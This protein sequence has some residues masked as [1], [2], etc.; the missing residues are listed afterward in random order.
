MNFVF[1]II[2]SPN[3]LCTPSMMDIFFLFPLDPIF[4]AT[5]SS[6]GR[7]TQALFHAPSWELPDAL[8][9]FFSLHSTGN[10]T[11]LSSSSSRS[12]RISCL[13]HR[14]ANTLFS[15]AFP[16]CIYYSSS[17]PHIHFLFF[18]FFRSLFFFFLTL[19]FLFFVFFHFLCLSVF[20]S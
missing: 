11:I 3:V 4:Y 8:M 19:L 12:S 1:A 15:L 18:S 9:V 5:H 20:Q 6:R 7:C 10:N 13:L 14:P 17:L 2:N 16:L